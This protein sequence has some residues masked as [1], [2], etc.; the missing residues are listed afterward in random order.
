M[1]APITRNVLRETTQLFFVAIA[2]AVTARTMYHAGNQFFTE[3]LGT[4]QA[5]EYVEKLLERFWNI[6][7]LTIFL[8]MALFAAVIRLLIAAF[9]RAV[10]NKLQTWTDEREFDYW[11]KWLVREPLKFTYRLADKFARWITYLVGLPCALV[12]DPNHHVGWHDLAITFNTRVVNNLT[13][14]AM[15]AVSIMLVFLT[16]FLVITNFIKEPSLG[17]LENEAGVANGGSLAIEEA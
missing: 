9:D 13:L 14:D 4:V 11:H 16:T 7:T 6:E 3:K 10:L 1:K 15:G 2:G 5:I 8:V 12:L 17:W